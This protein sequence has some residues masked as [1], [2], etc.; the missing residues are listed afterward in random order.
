MTATLPPIE[1]VGALAPL[2]AA[3]A[4]AMERERRLPVPV[5]DALQATGVFR[6]FIPGALG[7]AE[8]DP[9]TACRII[10]AVSTMDGAAGWCAMIGAC[11]G[12]FAGLLPEPAARE[13]FADPRAIVAGSFRPAGVARVVADGYRVTGRWPFGSGITH[14]TWVLG[15]C[16][17]VEHEQPRRT[18]AGTPEVRLLFFPP[19]DVE[20]LDT[21]HVAGLRGTGSHDYAVADLFVPAHRTCWF[22]EPP[23]Q[24]GPLYTLPAI[25]LFAPLIGCVA[26]GIA[27]HALDGFTELAGAK[28]PVGSQS[29]L[30]DKPVAQAQLGEAEGLLRAGR[31]FLYETV[32]AAW[33]TA[34]RGE[35]LSWE[36]RG[37]LW[38]AATQA[39]TQATQA[40]DLL[41]RAGGASSIYATLPLERCLRDV[42]TAAQHIC[43]Q[44]TNYELA[45][46][47]FLGAEMGS[48]LWGLDHRGDACWGHAGGGA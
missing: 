48:T 22:S 39:A 41:F 19:A 47:L 26:L 15:G 8:A 25:A 18:A 17:I 14:S 13:V 4:D 28:K 35:R 40:V 46:Q 38:L 2:I 36:Q 33:E 3:H 24:P 30:R 43:V 32:T 1:A 9:L 37:L 11:Y 31:A 42:R 34:T 23:V 5:V 12:L 29:L 16:Q 20:V 7:G 27:R 21:W 6:L 10:E 45:G 44:A